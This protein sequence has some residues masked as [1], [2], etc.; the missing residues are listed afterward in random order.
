MID[1]NEMVQRQQYG[2]E[3]LNQLQEDEKTILQHYCSMSAEALLQVGAD[4]KAPVNEVIINAMKNGIALG[5]KLNIQN[6]EVK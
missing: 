3:L 4:R 1:L 6:G 2:A 5:L